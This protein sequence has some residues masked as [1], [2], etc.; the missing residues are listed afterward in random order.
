MKNLII[1]RG[2]PAVGKGTLSMK[3]SEKLKGKV[4]KLTL[5]DFQWDMTAHQKRTRK[6]FEISFKNYLFVL[7]NYLKNNY[8]IIAED[9]WLRYYGYPD[10]S[11][12]INKIIFLGKKYKAKIT[13]ILLKAKWNTIK[14]RNKV[15]HRVMKGKELKE[16]YEKI[17]SRKIKNEQLIFV[18]GKSTE[19]ITKEVL[20]LVK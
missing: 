16:V 7:E 3:L 6:D 18:D 10:K 9:V 2:C 14:S 15:R 8:T 4:A 20:K 11:T 12:D 19:Q 1:I 13:L 17:Y 5:D